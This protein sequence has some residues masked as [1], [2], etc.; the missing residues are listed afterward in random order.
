[1]QQSLADMEYVIIDEMS[2]VG[3]KFIGHIDKRMC[4]EFPHRA[5]T[6]WRLLMLTL[7]RLW[8]A[9]SCDGSPDLHH[10]I[11]FSLDSA[12]YQHFHSAI[13]LTQVMCQSG[14]YPDQ[15]FRDILLHLRDGKLTVSDWVQLMKQT[16]A[17]ISDLPP[18]PL[19]FIILRKL[20]WSTMSQDSVLVATQ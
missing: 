6:F 16:L 13:V 4:Q 17:K 7:Q 14:Q 20:F 18:R 15:M 12:A 9:S 8:A 1:M 2:M 5:D 19:I 3:R 11:T 10:C